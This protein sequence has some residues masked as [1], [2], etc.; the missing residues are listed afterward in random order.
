MEIPIP[1][2][3][4]FI[5]RLTWHRFNGVSG[6]H[7]HAVALVNG[8]ILSRPYTPISSYDDQGLVDFIIKVWHERYWPF[9]RGIH[10]W[11]VDSPH[12]GSV[13]WALMLS[14]MVVQKLM[15]KQYGCHIESP[16][17]QFCCH[18]WHS[19]LSVWQPSVRQSRQSRFLMAQPKCVHEK[20][21]SSHRL[22]CHQL[23]D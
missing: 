4:V 2:K 14:L 5:L 6:Q 19:R 7:V 1:V 17:R 13:T 22:S 18:W 23:Y 16:G 20:E 21:N 11:Q 10:R 9:V 15:N 8:E 3:T 12:K